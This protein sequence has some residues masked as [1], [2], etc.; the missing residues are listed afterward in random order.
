M[1]NQEQKIRVTK[2]TFQAL[3]SAGRSLFQQ[4]LQ[5]NNH[6]AE[7]LI[8]LTLLNEAIDEGHQVLGTQRAAADEFIRL[9]TGITDAQREN[10]RLFLEQ[11]E[12]L[13]K[14]PTEQD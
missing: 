14:Q 11:E 6:S 5:S 8:Y 2:K 3:H 1:P 10:A 13:T 7:T 4:A 9:V 12:L